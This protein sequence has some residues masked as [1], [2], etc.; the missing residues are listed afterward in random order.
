MLDRVNE[1][2]KETNTKPG[3]RVYIKRRALKDQNRKLAELYEG[4]F[5]VLEKY[6][7]NKFLLR[8]LLDN[9]ELTVHSDNIKLVN[10][11]QFLFEKFRG[12]K[13]VDIDNNED[14]RECTFEYRNNSNSGCADES[15]RNT[16]ATAPSRY[17]LRK[18]DRIS[19]KE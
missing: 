10:E 1:K 2:A 3:Q 14:S 11:P 16:S 7:T 18:R 6:S 17:N 13:N 5:R 19:Y 15:A 9:K 8:N 4:P 12:D